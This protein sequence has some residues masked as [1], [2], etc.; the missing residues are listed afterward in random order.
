MLCTRTFLPTYLYLANWRGVSTYQLPLL[1]KRTP[2]SSRDLN[3]PTGEESSRRTPRRLRRPGRAQV[4]YCTLLSLSWQLINHLPSYHTYQNSGFKGL[5]APAM[6]CDAMRWDERP[7]WE[8]GP[9]ALW[10]VMIR[11]SPHSVY[12]SWRLRLQQIG[13]AVWLSFVRPRGSR[14]SDVCNHKV[15]TEPELGRLDGSRHVWLNLVNFADFP[16]F[17]RQIL[18]ASCFSI[19]ASVC[20]LISYRS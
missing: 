6:R 11:F 13:L 7:V 18:L 8:H 4:R 17:F 16:L 14:Q 9:P 5:A 12:A 20:D 1:A 15:G 19:D 2:R 3:L 10:L